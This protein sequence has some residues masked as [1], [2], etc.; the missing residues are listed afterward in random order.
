MLTFEQYFGKRINNR[1]AT[2]V[3]KANAVVLITRVNKLIG[4]Y[5]RET[6]QK[7]QIDED[8]GTQ[9]SGSR[10]GSGDGGFRLA[11]SRTGVKGSSHKQGMGIDIYDAR[12]L[13]DNW[14]SAHEYV[15]ED[16]DLYREGPAYT[17]GWVHLQ[18]RPTSR[19]TYRP[20]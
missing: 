14:I 18:T 6:D 15:L 12:N 16:F 13:F 19:R 11:Q 1:Y 5:E 7:I 2:E 10:G 8:T 17:P 3:R 4:E 9:I 20:Y